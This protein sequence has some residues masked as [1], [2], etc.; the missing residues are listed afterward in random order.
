MQKAK[1]LSRTFSEKSQAIKMDG[2]EAPRNP[3]H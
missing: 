2:D 1:E 3:F